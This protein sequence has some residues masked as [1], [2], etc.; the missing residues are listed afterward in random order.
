MEASHVA[1]SLGPGG[2]KFACDLNGYFG[3]PPRLPHLP[4]T[5]SQ[6][7]ALERLMKP[8]RS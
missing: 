4:P 5:G 3:G 7:T 8:L 1:E 2:L 6:R